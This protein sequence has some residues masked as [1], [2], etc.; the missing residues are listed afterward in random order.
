MRTS[1]IYESV[2]NRIIAE[3]EKG[4]APW[5][6]P[7][8]S[9]QAVS[10]MGCLPYNA[11]TQRHYSGINILTLWDAAVRK[12]SA[13]P[14]WLTF[15][16]AKERGG[17]IR[18]G[19]KGTHVV[20]T[21][22]IEV[23]E[24]ADD[25]STKKKQIS[26]M[27]SYVVFNVEQVEGLPV[28]FYSAPP[29]LPEEESIGYVEQFIAKTDA[30][31]RHGEKG[32][33]YVPSHD[34]IRMP[35]Y[36]L[37][38]TAA[39]YYATIFHELG[40]WSGHESRLNRDLTGRFGTRAYAAEELIAE[41]SAAFLC[42]SFGIEGHLRHAGYIESWLELLKSDKRAIFTAGSK[43]SQAAEYLAGFRHQTQTIGQPNRD[44]LCLRD[45]TEARR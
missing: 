12:G 20:F 3:L 40:H 6:K 31:I 26:M 22:R 32:A 11:V 38:K 27:R 37:F 5:V 9:G 18:K 13:V 15:N 35:S 14:A 8:K 29:V 16:Q 23:D 25:G 33:C 1:E 36:A 17:Y 4:A 43:A 34:F 42:A 7:W 19:E 41:L 45:H 30:D 2:T 39:H 21:K 44:G 10:G 28:Q 24:K